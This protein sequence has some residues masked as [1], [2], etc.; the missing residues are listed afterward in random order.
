MKFEEYIESLELEEVILKDDNFIHES[1]EEI[2]VTKTK[3]TYIVALK[4]FDQNEKKYI[5]R[6]NELKKIEFP[7]DFEGFTE[8]FIRKVQINYYSILKDFLQIDTKSVKKIKLTADKDK[9][10]LY[11][12]SYTISIEKYQKMLSV[13]KSINNRANSYRTS[14][15]RYL[16]NERKTDFKGKTTKRTTSIA[17]GEFNFLINRFNID[18]KEK[19]EEFKKYLNET[20]IQSVQQL[21]EKLI[22]HE[23]FD[24]EFLRGLDEY[25]IK[26]KLQDIV[27]IGREILTIGRNDIKTEKAKRVIKKIVGKDG[28]EIKQLEN[29]WQ[30]YFEKY[31]LYLIFSYRKIY[32]KIQFEIDLEKKYPDFLGINHYWGVDI[33]EIKHHL[34]P[35]LIYDKSHK[36]YAFSGDLSKAIIQTMNYSDALIREKF[37]TETDI[38]DELKKSILSKNIHRPRGIIIISSKENLVKTNKKLT[39]KQLEYIERDFT[40]LRNSLN[41]IEILTFDE[42]LNTADYYSTNIIKKSAT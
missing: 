19:P 4:R 28:K 9:F 15:L 42:I 17:K 39:K 25:F 7:V 5:D 40:K 37:K 31:L 35:A 26:E 10:R 14:A 41:N 2:I 21:T 23:V 27:K 16:V 22:K 6:Y 20:D 1:S 13:A 36:N 34:L 18:K 30:T 29:I 11:K 12:G 24:N 33:I 3:N 32:P 38:Q 8:L